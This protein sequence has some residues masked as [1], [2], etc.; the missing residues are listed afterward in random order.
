MAAVIGT[1]ASGTLKEVAADRCETGCD[2]SG[3]HDKDHNE[4]IVA[5]SDSLHA[6][7]VL[8]T[9]NATS[10]ES[11]LLVTGESGGVANDTSADI[12]YENSRPTLSVPFVSLD[13]LVNDVLLPGESIR[14][15]KIETSGTEVDIIRRYVCTI[16]SS[17]QHVE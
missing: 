6:D 12:A 10:I 17:P 16:I 7:P 4:N 1:Q 3:L 14:L 15:A 13:G 11:E 5:S 2:R 8:S 9:G